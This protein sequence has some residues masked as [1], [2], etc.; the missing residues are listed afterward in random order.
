MS[1][2]AA[3]AMAFRVASPAVGAQKNGIYGICVLP[4][5]QFNLV[6]HQINTQETLKAA[7]IRRCDECF[8]QGN[9]GSRICKAARMIN[10]RKGVHCQVSVRKI[11]SKAV[12][13]ERKP[14]RSLH[15]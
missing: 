10:A 6:M 14:S 9:S 12:C 3:P 11:D 7:V 15:S 5:Q 4:L 13:C 2:R 1:F 8:N